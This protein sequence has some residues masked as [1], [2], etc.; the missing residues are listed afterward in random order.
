MRKLFAIPALALGVGLLGCDGGT[1]A[2]PDA[3]TPSLITRG[4]EL[5]G[6]AHPEVV[7]II[8]DVAGVPT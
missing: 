8:M 1:T 2:L 6:E 4:G 7:L 3:T 5:A